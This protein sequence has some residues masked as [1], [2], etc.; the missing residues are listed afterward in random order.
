MT[1]N[2]G[3]GGSVALAG[4]VMDFLRG[5][6]VEL[7]VGF[8]HQSIVDRAAARQRSFSMS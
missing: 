5:S 8:R 3:S 1:L 2:F 4:V 6:G 7:V